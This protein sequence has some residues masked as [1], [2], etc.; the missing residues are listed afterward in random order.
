MFFLRSSS[1][2]SIYISLHHFLL[3]TQSRRLLFLYLGPICFLAIVRLQCP[4]HFQS[5][6]L[7]HGCITSYKLNRGIYVDDGHTCNGYLNSHRGVYAIYHHQPTFMGTTWHI[8]GTNQK[9]LPRLSTSVLNSTPHWV[10]YICQCSQDYYLNFLTGPSIATPSCHLRSWRRE[11]MIYKINN[12]GIL[13]RFVL[14][15][16]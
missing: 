4:S 7:S 6:N 9:Q 2:P 13:F 14:W 16:S 11:G 5:W 8:R 15:E 1:P 3:H 10:L 12:H